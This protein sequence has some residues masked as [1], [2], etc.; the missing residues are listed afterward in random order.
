VQSV[1]GG[2]IL[3]EMAKEQNVG[4]DAEGGQTVQ[5]REFR[6]LRESGDKIGVTRAIGLAFMR[7]RNAVATVLVRLGVTPNGV[8]IAG[9]LATCGAG[10]CFAR[11][12]SQQV[13]YF[14][15][16]DGPAGWWPSVA[17]L[18][19]ILA[20]ACDMLDGAVARIG[21]SATTF[22][23]ILDSTLDR[24]SDMAVYLGCAVHFAWQGNVTYQVLALLA[25]SNTNM[26]SYV[27]ARAEEALP[28]CSVGWWLRGERCV[29]VLI[30]CLSGH[31]G[32][33]LLQQTVLPFFTVMRRV[34]FARASAAALDAGRPLP[35]GKPDPGW[36]GLIRPW[37]HPRGSLL[38]DFVAGFNI[39]SI[40]VFP[41]IFPALL[42]TGDYADPLTRWLGR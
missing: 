15:I 33:V 10:Y 8:T 17:A 9:F 3:A 25:L 28:D 24:F 42:A 30:G 26:I 2:D 18:F 14:R 16:G 39:A 13:P 19:L 41:R 12:A 4:G 27:K 11:G 21:K 20:G 34:N 35:T 5:T 31:M 7:A 37:R 6:S 36:R 40:I 32:F 23:G 29:A 1:T 38:F 22:G